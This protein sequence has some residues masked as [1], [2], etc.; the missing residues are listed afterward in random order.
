[1]PVIASA[2]AA[3]GGW[4]AAGA[5][6]VGL[7]TAA[8]AIGAVVESVV[9]GAIYG[10]LIGGATSA[11]TGGDILTGALKG[12]A[13][14][15]V[16]AGVTT[17]LSE[18]F[19]SATTTTDVSAASGLDATVAPTVTETGI[20]GATDGLT[21]G[22]GATMD[23]G[24]QLMKN[25]ETGINTTATTASDLASGAKS[26]S[27]GLLASAKEALSNKEVLASGLEGTFKG[28]GQ[29]AAAKMEADS[30]EEKAQREAE[31]LEEAKAQN[32]VGEFEVQVANIKV[33]N[34]W[35]K[36]LNPAFKSNA[37]TNAELNNKAAVPSVVKN[38]TANNNGL[39]NGAMV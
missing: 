35:N 22:V 37:K 17:G 24:A 26:T 31:I 2:A 29:I 33:P 13:I 27:N 18:A 21:Q 3:I 5:T 36:Y 10:A 1:M 15:G 14:G 32:K 9:V 28:F 4:A 8:T 39:L 23:K 19:S 16:T 6:A 30:A 12:A 11:I 7:A 25:A 34:W 20:T 38:Q